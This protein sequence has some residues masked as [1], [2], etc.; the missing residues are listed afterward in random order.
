M[1]AKREKAKRSR[2]GLRKTL[3][4]SFLRFAADGPSSGEVA[5]PNV[6]THSKEEDNRR[7]DIDD[8][9]KI[10]GALLE[11]DDDPIPLVNRYLSKD[12]KRLQ[13]Q[14]PISVK[15][16]SIAVKLVNGG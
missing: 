10:L 9:G 2:P 14:E 12:L 4:D 16:G 3:Q 11:S 15:S 13:L 6:Q 8:I 7:R 1:Q 5:M